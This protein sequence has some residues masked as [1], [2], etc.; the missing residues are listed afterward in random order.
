[1]ART[2]DSGQCKGEHKFKQMRNATFNSHKSAVQPTSIKD[3]SFGFCFS[4]N[5][6]KMKARTPATVG[7]R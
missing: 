2:A 5:Y 3:D 6:N 4:W 7:Q 1:M